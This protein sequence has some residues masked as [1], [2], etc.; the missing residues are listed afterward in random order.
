MSDITLTG[1]IRANLLSL[2]RTT[3]MI[4]DTQFKMSTGKKVN[5][6][7]DNAVSFFKAQGLNFRS[8]DLML[9]KD[10]IQQGMNTLQA[11]DKGITSVLKLVE[12]AEAKATQAAELGDASNVATKAS[13]NQSV[14]IYDT[15][16]TTDMTIHVSSAGG[17]VQF[18][19]DI[20]A[21]DT[22]QTALAKV[23]NAALAN[24]ANL[25]VS[26]DVGSQSFEVDTGDA[27]EAIAFS[28]AAGGGAKSTEA[29][30][31]EF[32]EDT[33]T[34]AADTTRLDEYK[35]D[36]NDI[37]TQIDSLV[38]D[39]SF[40]G[41]NLIN[42]GDA[43]NS[44]TIKFNE[45]GSSSL[46]I[47]GKDLTSDSGLGLS[48]ATWSAASDAEGA[49]SNIADAKVELRDAAASFGTKNAILETRNN[50]TD[51]LTNTLDKGAGDLVNADM[52][53]ESANMLSLQTRQ[54]LGTISLSIAN[55]AEQSVLR[56]F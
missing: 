33:F 53:Q 3:S 11:A 10:G 24:G 32:V 39:A 30:W 43:S 12:Q 44:M 41:K 4:E 51:D 18:D 50:F 6:A 1:G 40:Q 31:T 26:F 28:S 14:S 16:S 25:T 37:L 27:S 13:A 19:V 20:K 8:N 55:Q 15:F 52:N 21:D 34:V 47:Q 17:V 46:T 54:Q 45:D 49:L 22:V 42:S 23:N 2:Q 7:L 5:S 9:R 36:Y 48:Q 29:I 38:G 56:L 35:Q